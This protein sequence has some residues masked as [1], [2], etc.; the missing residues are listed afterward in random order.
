MDIRERVSAVAL[1]DESS[2]AFGEYIH[3]TCDVDGAVFTLGA[4]GA[5]SI[6]WGSEVRIAESRAGARARSRKV[7]A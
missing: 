2:R 5:V 6:G 4:H 7:K 3:F 1:I